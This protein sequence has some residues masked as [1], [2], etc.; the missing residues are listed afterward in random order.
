M[1]VWGCN[2]PV[3][4]LVQLKT[5]HLTSSVIEHSFDMENVHVIAAVFKLSVCNLHP[6]CV[7]EGDCD[8]CLEPKLAKRI[9]Y[10]AL[11]QKIDIFDSSAFHWISRTSMCDL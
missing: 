9:F 10:P 6:N 2:S 5:T 11:T 1:F 3:E 8:A 7:L 4:S